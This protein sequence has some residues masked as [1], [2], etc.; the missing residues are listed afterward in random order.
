MLHVTGGAEVKWL[1]Q[2]FTHF[3][4]LSMSTGVFR[5]NDQAGIA[6]PHLDDAVC[7]VCNAQ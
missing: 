3:D 2:A 6:S 5:Q 4:R 1:S 7:R